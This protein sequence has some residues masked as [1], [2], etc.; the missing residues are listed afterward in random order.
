MSGINDAFENYMEMILS[1]GIDE[2]SGNVD[3]LSDFDDEV[4]DEDFSSYK[5]N[6]TTKA[7]DMDYSWRENYEYDFDH[8]IDPEDY[9]TEEEYLEALEEAQSGIESNTICLP[10]LQVTTPLKQYMSEV[11][12]VTI[13]NCCKVAINSNKEQLD[14]LFEN[15][16]LNIGDQ[17]VVSLGFDNEK[18]G[19]VIAVGQYLECALSCD[20]NKMK[21]V[22]GLLSKNNNVEARTVACKKETINE[23]IIFEDHN[24]KIS[25][26]K[27]ERINYLVGGYA[28]TGTFVFENKSDKR[29]C[30]YMKDISVC[31]FLNLSESMTATLDGK[32]K[33]I[34]AIPLVYENKIPEFSKDFNKVEF[35]V[36]YGTIRKGLSAICLIDKPTIESE[37][38][39]VQI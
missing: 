30:I 35:K 16:T 3:D 37:I 8:N 23:N 28:K 1:S 20:I 6:F 31:G 24:I 13:Y 15:L 2:S 21:S 34:K 32:Q 29:L 18:D 10:K 12:K 5:E 33:E 7:D 19:T 14:C 17:V 36:C 38:V 11:E 39:S 22:I 25:F 4:A 9:E 26:I 27:W